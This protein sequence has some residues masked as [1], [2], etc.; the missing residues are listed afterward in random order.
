MS[1][2]EV[3]SLDCII[4]DYGNIQIELWKVIYFI[5]AD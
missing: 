1:P 4:D 3:V 5:K 2:V